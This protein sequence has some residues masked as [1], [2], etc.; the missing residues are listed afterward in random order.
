MW[1]Y[2]EV[3]E[4]VEAVCWPRR[5]KLKAKVRY[6]RRLR[7]RC[8]LQVWRHS[9]L[10]VGPW[11][12]AE[13][14]T[15]EHCECRLSEVQGADEEVAYVDLGRYLLEEAVLLR[16]SKAFASRPETRSKLRWRTQRPRR[17]MSLGFQ[18]SASAPSHFIRGHLAHSETTPA[19]LHYSY[20]AVR[21][22]WVSP[23]G[24]EYRW[25]YRAW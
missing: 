9:E 14:K 13:V 15:K 6:E 11:P 3:E 17:P 4:G 23:R 18:S 8:D 12:Q 16:A 5:V 22:R 19:L 10:K 7:K 2:L 24:E 25:Q 21:E 1:G 20:A